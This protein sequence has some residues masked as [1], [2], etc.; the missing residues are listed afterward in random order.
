MGLAA[1]PV[2][3]EFESGYQ[4]TGGDPLLGEDRDAPHVPG[5]A[6]FIVQPEGDDDLRRVYLLEPG[7]DGKV[8]LADVDQNLRTVRL[9]EVS[10]AVFERLAARLSVPANRLLAYD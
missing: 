4:T 9:A 5:I 7:P 8:E 10:D 3:L 2:S 6:V 1:D